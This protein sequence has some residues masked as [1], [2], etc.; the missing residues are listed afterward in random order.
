MRPISK[1]RTVILL[2]DPD[3][4]QERILEKCEVDVL[5]FIGK[6]RLELQKHLYHNY[7]RDLEMSSRTL[8]LLAQRFA[9]ALGEKAILPFDSGNSRFVN[10]RDGWRVEIQP[11]KGR[12]ERIQIPISKTEVPYYDAIQDMSEYPFYIARENDK[13]FVYVS[14]PVNIEAGSNVIGID[15]NMR[16]WVAAPASQ[17]QPLFFDASGYDKE[18]EQIQKKISR[19]QSQIVLETAKKAD[20]K[21]RYKKELD[22][23]YEDLKLVVKRAHGNFLSQLR[24]K[25]G[26]C[27]LALENIDVLYQMRDNESRM[28]NIWLYKK[29]ALRQF[30]LRAMAHGFNVVE[31]TPRGT[32]HNCHRCD[33]EGEI[34]G[35]H[36]RLFRCPKCGLKDYHR[37]LNAARN[38]AKRSLEK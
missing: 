11:L 33:S 22:P 16:S 34:Y 38:I 28:T 4:S 12:G 31:I 23:L 37:D 32:S 2:A 26:V 5:K 6:S 17:F 27:T 9:G 3:K 13:W 30:V 1:Y 7:K 35:T 10:N 19:A 25:Y 20:R 36:Q 29:T 14:I 15:F 24:D 21:P 8:C 18:V